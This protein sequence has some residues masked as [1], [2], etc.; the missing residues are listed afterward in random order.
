MRIVGHL[1]LWPLIVLGVAGPTVLLTPARVQYAAVLGDIAG[2]TAPSYVQA[3]LPFVVRD[4]YAAQVCISTSSGRPLLPFLVPVGQTSVITA[5]G[6]TG[7]V[8]AGVPFVVRDSNG[9][10][11]CVSTKGGRSFPPFIAP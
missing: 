2:T 5:A 11:V 3:G 8:Q 4:S 1:L 9:T 6:A 7:D 10:Q